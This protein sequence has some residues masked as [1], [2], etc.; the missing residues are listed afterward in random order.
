MSVTVLDI[1]NT[2]LAIMD[3]SGTSDY[4]K[5]TP[6]IV[7]SMMGA[8]WMASEQHHFGPHSM[9]TPVTDMSDEVSGVD[10]SLAL[11]AMPYGLAAQLYLGEDHVRAG[12]WWAIFEERLALFKRNRPAEFESID[13]YYGGCE[14]SE[15]G[16]W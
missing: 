1:Y 7:N 6:P 3:E 14:L 12:S 5:R 16:R 11:S 8:V 10:Q 9:W 4:E 15:F 2:A 13:N